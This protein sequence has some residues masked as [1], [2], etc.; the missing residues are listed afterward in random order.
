MDWKHITNIGNKT[1]SINL[2]SDIGTISAQEFANEL[3]FLDNMQLDSIDIHINSKGGSVFEGFGILMAIKNATTH[4]TTINDGIAFSMAG[5]VMQAGDTRKMVDF[6]QLM[7]HDPAFSNGTEP[8]NEKQKDILQRI[9]DSLVQIFAGATRKKK[10][11]TISKLM[12]NET[13]FTA[14]EALDAGLIDEIVPT[15]RKKMKNATVE[16]ILNYANDLQITKTKTNKMENLTNHFEL[17]N[18]A[19]EADVL[20]KVTEL[21]SK[22]ETAEKQAKEEKTNHEGTVTAL[23]DADKEIENLK[24]EVATLTVEGAIEAGKVDEKQKDELI[25][26]A[27]ENIEN[28]R[29]FMGAVKTAA[30]NITTVIDNKTEEEVKELSIIDWQKNDPKGLLDIMNND[31]EKYSEMYEKHYGVKPKLN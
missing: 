17:E 23:N 18:D 12:A 13:F 3:M 22:L 10:P 4:T 20:A 29:L 6:G 21:E 19:T 26:S 1:A 31:P 7:I 14:Q 28:F 27:T 9:K 30:A 8:E 15:S 11:E 2:F 16:E 24:K 5:V 25:A